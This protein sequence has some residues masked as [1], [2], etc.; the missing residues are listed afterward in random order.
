MDGMQGENYQLVIFPLGLNRSADNTPSM[1]FINSTQDK[2]AL[3]GITELEY[4]TK[5]EDNRY[6]NTKL[7]PEVPFMDAAEVTGNNPTGSV[8]YKMAQGN[9]KFK[10]DAATG[11][12]SCTDPSGLTAGQYSLVIEVTEAGFKSVDPDTGQETGPLITGDKT[13]YQKI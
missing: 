8:T 6:V 11:A 1:R 2:V 9:S 5:N 7:T 3:Y 13:T 4:K 10:V 12:L